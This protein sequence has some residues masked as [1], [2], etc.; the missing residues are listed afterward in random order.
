MPAVSFCVGW[1]SHPR[2]AKQRKREKESALNARGRGSSG[3]LVVSR[4]CSANAHKRNDCCGDS[5]RGSET[6]SS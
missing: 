5:A 4:P 1:L 6:E 2:V 3:D